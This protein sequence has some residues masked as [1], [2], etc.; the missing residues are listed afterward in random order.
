[1]AVIQLITYA[2]ALVFFGAVIVRFVKLSSLPIHVRWELYPVAHE[3][4]KAHYGGSY[5]EEPEWWTKPREISLLGEAKVMIPEILLLHGVWQHNKKH[6]FRSWPF[7]FGL[8]LLI[9]MVF[10][11]VVGGIATAAGADVS[12][13]AGGLWGLVHHVTAGLGYGGL[14]LGFL[15]ASALLTRR[16]MEVEYREYTKKSDLF[17]L[18]FFVVT[19]AV[20]LIVHFSIDPG[21]S[22]LRGYFARLVTFD[23]S[24]G[25]EAS[26]LMLTEIALASLLVAYIPLTH[27]SHFFTKY[28]MYHDIRWSDEPNLRGSEIE[29]KLSEPL[30]YPVTWSADHI[31]GDG[32][33]TW[34]D[35]ATSGVEEDE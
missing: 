10:F 13:E 2:S 5:L 23:L 25:G 35:V 21:F 15:G 22:G 31:R 3:K 20:A 29:R 30:S 34:V 28:F 12:A 8:Y 26:G 16:L 24:G 9:G 19:M 33:K 32:K 7:H 18:A 17:N 14:V 6:W 1:M 11:L 27:M 4:G